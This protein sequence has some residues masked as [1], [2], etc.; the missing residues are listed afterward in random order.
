MTTPAHHH[1]LAAQLRDFFRPRPK[2]TVT[3]WC[4]RCLVFDEPQNNGPFNLAGSEYMRAGLDDWGDPTIRR[5]IYVQGTQT[6]KTGGIMGGAAWRVF[7]TPTRILW[8][9]PTKDLVENFSKT[10]WLKMLKASPQFADL[11]P[12]GNR[13]HDFKTLQ[14]MVG[15]SIVD[16]T[17]SNSPAALSSTPAPDVVLDEVDKFPSITGGGK[18]ADAV[19]LAEQRTKSFADYKIVLTSTPTLVDG[20]I[21]QELLNSDFQRRFL[22]C[23]LCP[24]SVPRVNKMILLAWS[25][26]F[27]TLPI[28]GTEAFVKWDQ[29]AKRP[30]GSWDLDRVERSARFECPHC[31][32]HIRD[33]HKTIMD[34]NGEWR[35]TKEASRSIRGRHLP[36][37]YAASE[38][39][40][41]GKLAVQFIK[42]KRSLLGLQGFVNNELAEPWENQRS[43]NTRI[44]LVTRPDADRLEQARTFLDVDVQIVAPYFWFVVREWSPTASR[45]VDYG[46]LDTWEEVRAKQL[47]HSLPDNQVG[48]DSGDDTENVYGRCQAYGELRRRLGEL[49]IWRGWLPMKGMDEKR[50]GGWKDP[51]T[52]APRPFTL[53]WAAL[54][55]RKFRL[56]LLEF[57]GHALKNMLA[58]MRQGKS[59]Y[60]WEV[61]EAAE[62]DPEYWKHLDAEVLKPFYNPRTNRVEHLWA[63]KSKRWPNHLLDCEVMSLAHALFFKIIR[64]ETGTDRAGAPISE[65]PTPNSENH[66]EETS[67]A[68]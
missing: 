6:R 56:P 61:T 60:A 35:P 7:N 1:R 44:E 29:E 31:G 45:L 24:D 54:A 48:I 36:S 8:V 28:L 15:S 32:G 23:P 27:T 18:E 38:Q 14:Q 59:G 2:E 30:D 51:K 41:V 52:G 20:L 37:L 4:C 66:P 34:R 40:N 22:E 43:S 47:E 46:T 55:H 17:W 58:R 57:S 62:K 5:Q 53:G 19:T 68:E 67:H 39:R 25:K 33:A 21:W 16:F 63:K 26:S 9:M 49:P 12:G 65:T 64:P 50:R 11:I 3:D 10:R 13:R 42:D